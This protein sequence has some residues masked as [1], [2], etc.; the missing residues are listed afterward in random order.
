MKKRL[1]LLLVLAFCAVYG[2]GSAVSVPNHSGQEPSAAWL[3][4]VI[5]IALYA[6]ATAAAIYLAPKTPKTPDPEASSPD[7]FQ[8]PKAEEG[9][10]IPVL[11][12][13]KKVDGMNVVDWG[14]VRATKVK[15][16]M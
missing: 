10:S 6:L 4:F 9:S 11:F 3:N 7:D 12:G 8:V 16:K 1:L 14:N 5:M 15:E 13:T 2:G